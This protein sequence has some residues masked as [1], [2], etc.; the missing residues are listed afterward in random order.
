V[1]LL[2]SNR[3]IALMLLAA[4]PILLSQRA[5]AYPS[6]DMPPQ[7]SNA[8]TAGIAIVL[9]TDPKGA[10]VEPFVQS[11]R[12]SVKRKWHEGIPAS[13][14]RG[15]KGRVA[16]EFRVQQDGKLVDGSVKVSSSSGK[17][18]LDEA[19]VNA[20]RAA[21]P[22]GPLPDKFSQPFIEMRIYFYYNTP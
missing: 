17:K 21:A 1:R 12:V 19:G 7:S 6:Q 20:I 5:L 3:L 13:A 8:P 4:T 15:D 16:V 22:F 11:L 9:L 10:D 2:T 18:D 14:R